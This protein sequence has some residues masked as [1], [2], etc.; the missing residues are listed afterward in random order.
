MSDGAASSDGPSQE[1]LAKLVDACLLQRLSADKVNSYHEIICLT[2][3]GTF[4]ERIAFTNARE[5]FIIKYLSFLPLLSA[6]V[7][8][9]EKRFQESLV[10]P[11]YPSYLV[12]AL[13]M[14][15]LQPFDI[16][17]TL[18]KTVPELQNLKKGVAQYPLLRVITE[19]VPNW[20]PSRTSWA[21]T[22]LLWS[23]VRLVH[24][25]TNTEPFMRDQILFIETIQIWIHIIGSQHLRPLFKKEK[26]NN[27]GIL[28]ETTAD[29]DAW[30]SFDNEYHNICNA[31]ATKLP[32]SRIRE[33]DV[34]TNEFRMDLASVKSPVEDAA[35]EPPK[36]SLLQTRATLPILLIALV[37]PLSESSDLISARPWGLGRLTNYGG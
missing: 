24:K 21:D 8:L 19:T 33:L 11:L 37:C 5:G 14:H 25:F 13:N 1:L 17:K 28:H 36:I 20:R 32:F 4:S 6:D 2:I 27:T 18:T 34:I 15:L 26:E 7:F 23:L 10:D 22:E 16:L 12:K 3:V 35:P 31:V 29:T 9:D 30:K